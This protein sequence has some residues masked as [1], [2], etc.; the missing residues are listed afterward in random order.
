M[1]LNRIVMIIEFLLKVLKMAEIYISIIDNVDGMTSKKMEAVRY[2]LIRFNKEDKKH[3][4][5]EC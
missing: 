2:D 5:Y 1:G 3:W 4:T